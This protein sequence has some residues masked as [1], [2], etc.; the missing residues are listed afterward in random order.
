MSVDA[1]RHRHALRR[2]VE[3]QQH[4]DVLFL[5]KSHG[6]VDGDVGLALRVGVDRLDLVTLD[7][8][9]LDE[10]VE[11]D[12]GAG[13][14]QL[15]ACTGERAGQVV[16]DADLDLLLLRL[17]ARRHAEHRD[18]GRDTAYETPN[19]THGH[20]SL[21]EISVFFTFLLAGITRAAVA[22]VKA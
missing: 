4:V 2:R 6:F 17:G 1:G 9:L 5:D 16:D 13:V 14:L 10:V 21:P 3:A 11:H 7:P 20:A 8:A 19:L 22:D 15:R 12:L 18:R